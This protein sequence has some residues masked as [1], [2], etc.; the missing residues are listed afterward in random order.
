MNN[1]AHIYFDYN[2]AIITNVASVRIQEK[3]SIEE[4]EWSQFNHLLVYPN[5]SSRSLQFQNTLENASF[6]IYNL[7]G[8]VILNGNADS[9]VNTVDV[10][11]LSSG[12]YFIVLSNGFNAK[13]S[14]Q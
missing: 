8:K 14:I 4:N 11:G 5:P 13:I 1:R 2:E 6:T 12:I 9:G 10:S 3:S 7:N